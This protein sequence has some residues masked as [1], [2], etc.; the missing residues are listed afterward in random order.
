M[1]FFKWS[2]RILCLFLYVILSELKILFIFSHA[3]ED[4]KTCTYNVLIDLHF[5]FSDKEIL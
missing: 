5:A 1:I 2:T 3:V 4:V